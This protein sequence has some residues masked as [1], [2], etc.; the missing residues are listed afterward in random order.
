MSGA[1]GLTRDRGRLGDVGL[2]D[3]GPGDVVTGC[4]GVT[5][6]P[7]VTCVSYVVAGTSQILSVVNNDFFFHILS[8]SLTESSGLLRHALS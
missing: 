4:P 5:A 3:T 7:R 6:R 2:G 8:P 1:H